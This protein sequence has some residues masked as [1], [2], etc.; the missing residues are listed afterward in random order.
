MS[1]LTRRS[2]GP[3]LHPDAQLY[4]AV[5][6]VLA[7]A[8]CAVILG[9]HLALLADGSHTGLTWNPV[10]LGFELAKHQARWPR[11]ATLIAGVIVVHRW[12][13]CGGGVVVVVAA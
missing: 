7:V 8:A 9:A 5:S 13:R 2:Q 4:A 1:S 3:S 11:Y 10:R 6:V 12:R